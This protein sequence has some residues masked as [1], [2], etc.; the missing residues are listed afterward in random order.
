ML[1]GTMFERAMARGHDVEERKTKRFRVR[2]FAFYASHALV[3]GDF[4]C[5]SSCGS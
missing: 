3:V 5:K 1:L 2:M 4:V